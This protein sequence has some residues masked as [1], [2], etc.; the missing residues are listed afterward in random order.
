MNTEKS[1]SNVNFYLHSDVS[2]WMFNKYGEKDIS[3]FENTLGDS[4]NYCFDVIDQPFHCDIKAKE[5]DVSFL[6][7]I[8]A[9]FGLYEEQYAN[10][11]VIFHSNGDN[12]SLI[13]QSGIGGDAL[14]ICE[15]YLKVAIQ[16]R[17]QMSSSFFESLADLNSEKEGVLVRLLDDDV[18]F[19]RVAGKKRPSMLCNSL[20]EGMH[21]GRPY[22]DEQTSGFL[23]EMMSMDDKLAGAE[24]GDEDC[25][26]DVALTYLNG[27]DEVEQDFEK[28]AYWWE[29]LAE[30]GNSNALFNIGLFYAKGCGVTRSFEK[31]ADW[32]QKA[33]ENGDS[34]AEK[35]YTVYSKAAENLKK[36]E[37]GDAEA[38][39][40]MAK[41]FTQLGAAL[42]QYGTDN[43]Y[44]AAFEWAEKSAGQGC[45]EGLYCLALCYEHGRGV[46]E[47]IKKAIH[48][49]QK[50]VDA[51]H[52]GCQYNLGCNY[53]T[54]NGV[55]KDKHKAF[56]LIKTAAE[57]GN[58]LAM[59]EL[60]RCYQFANGTPG[61]MKTAV[62]WYEKALEVIDDPE[63]A[64]KTAIFKDMAEW[65]PSF[66]EDYPEDDSDDALGTV[67][68]AFAEE[69][70]DKVQ[71][72]KEKE[73]AEKERVK[74]EE[75]AKRLEE[76]KKK[77]EAKRLEEEKRKREQEAREQLEARRAAETGNRVKRKEL[78]LQ[79]F[80]KSICPM[81]RE[82][83][84][85]IIGQQM[86]I[87]GAAEEKLKSLGL[88]KRNQKQEQHDI[89]AECDRRIN[90][91][92]RL[93]RS[94]DILSNITPRIAADLAKEDREYQK[95]L[96]DRLFPAQNS[97]TSQKHNTLPTLQQLEEQEDKKIILDFLS[98]ASQP[99]TVEMIQNSNYRFSSYT[100][101]R[102]S[103]ILDSLIADGLVRSER[104]RR[105][106]IGTYAFLYAIFDK[107]NVD[108][109]VPTYD[110]MS[111]D[112]NN[113]NAVKWAVKQD[114]DFI[115]RQWQ[116]D[117]RR[118]LGD[119][120]IF[121]RDVVDTRQIRIDL[122]RFYEVHEGQNIQTLS[123]ILPDSLKGSFG[124]NLLASNC[125][126]DLVRH[127]YLM[128]P[129]W[130]NDILTSALTD[131]GIFI[132][133]L[134]RLFYEA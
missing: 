59:R 134:Y 51:G 49:Y 6:L 95:K 33:V 110:V 106:Y 36:A 102:I 63:L 54:G 13:N 24:D 25:M 60:G 113:S 20:F 100:K 61:N 114:L 132:L 40:E 70:E 22:V 65:D 50:G 83:Y 30:M 96:V 55:K 88:F 62:E 92:Q 34:D 131:K 122:L 109:S 82:E 112:F 38:Q 76:A 127:G 28:S 129:Y 98:H 15:Y 1:L 118:K 84:R 39:A 64:Q 4:D 120:D 99:M 85:A 67:P 105:Q 94:A 16:L 73:K 10:L 89:M 17:I 72:E 37:L 121:S 5:G 117:S 103:K 119:Y 26:A 42:D 3:D 2:K 11:H 80:A 52:D 125:E 41:V 107:P 56:E 81:M 43:D 69:Q 21:M 108:T 78:I 9:D 68:N 57:N 75:E 93:M 97:T 23:R 47:D 128:E 18:I 27:N 14:Q 87:K 45:P 111:I 124:A 104:D 71:T 116:Y 19:E 46:A 31:A 53:M 86:A 101:Y 126:N 7:F 66:D 130:K 133:A 12:P 74:K 29:K 123:S 115:L 77:R 91:A 58:G 35:L 8:R 79:T 32:M 90:G 48:Y 44:K